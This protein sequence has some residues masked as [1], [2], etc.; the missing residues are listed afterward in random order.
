[1]ILSRANHVETNCPPAVHSVPTVFVVDQDIAARHCLEAI[2]R[3]AGWQ[4]IS[5]GGVDEFLSC[6]RD[7]VPSCLIL[8]VSL[9]ET[10]EWMDFERRS[11]ADRMPVIVTSGH[12]DIPTAVRAIKAG[13]AEVLVKPVNSDFL[14]TVMRK[15]IEQSRIA[16]H[17][18]GQLRSL[19]DR[20]AS[21]SRR[22]RDVMR[23]V[24]TGLLN[25]QIG[26]ELGISE[27]TVKAHRGK[28]MLKMRATSLVD[29]VGM[30]SRLN[31]AAGNC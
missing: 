15:A 28:V 25:K 12:C 18:E 8:D 3:R 22:E 24:I 7:C 23:L 19:R 4:A 16:L 27:V 20:H 6:T 5:F 21:L 14:T 30:A 29:L 2:V 26:R 10:L 11:M 31:V 17:Q 13:A 1:M 9:P